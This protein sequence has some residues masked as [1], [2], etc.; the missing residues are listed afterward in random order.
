MKPDLSAMPFPIFIY[1]CGS[2]LLSFLMH[3]GKVTGDPSTAGHYTSWETDAQEIYLKEYS[4]RKRI[5]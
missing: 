3:N 5:Y 1:F 2:L 4:P